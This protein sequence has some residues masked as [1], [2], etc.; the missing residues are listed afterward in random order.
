MARGLIVAVHSAEPG[1]PLDD[2]A[3]DLILQDIRDQGAAGAVFHVL[4]HMTTFALTHINTARMARGEEPLTLV[5]MRSIMAAEGTIDVELVRDCFSVLGALQLPHTRRTS[6][7]PS[8]RMLRRTLETWGPYALVTV[9]HVYLRLVRSLAEYGDEDME[10]LLRC[11]TVAQERDLY[12]LGEVK[13]NGTEPRPR[14]TD[15]A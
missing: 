3:V 4:T 1:D 8:G 11:F 5:E 14:K 6:H 7:D 2:P 13:P 9:S 12:G 10:Y 15:G